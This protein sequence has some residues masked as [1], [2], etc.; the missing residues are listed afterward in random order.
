[1]QFSPSETL[2]FIRPCS[3]SPI[4]IYIIYIYTALRS[5]EARLAEP[6]ADSTRDLAI[7]MSSHGSGA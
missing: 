6:C 7:N 5:S 4:N 1:M 2:Q 3:S